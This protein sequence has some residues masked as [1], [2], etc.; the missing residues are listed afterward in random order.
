MLDRFQTLVTKLQSTNGRIEKEAFLREVADDA[1]V[2]EILKFLFDPYVVS[3]ISDKKLNKQK[4]AKCGDLPLL[5][6]TNDGGQMANRCHLSSDICH[7]LAYFRKNNTGRDEDVRYLVNAAEKSGHAE[8]VY[9]IIKRDLKLGIQATTLNKVFGEDFVAKFDV[10]LAESYADNPTFL[11][12]KEFII[13]EKLDGVRCLLMNTAGG[14]IDG[15]W[16]FYSRQ[17]QAILDLVELIEQ[18]KHLPCEF[19]YDGELLLSTKQPMPSKDLYR[20]TV[21]VTSSDTTK[22]NIVFNMFDMVDK[23]AFLRGEDPTPAIERKTR[24]QQLLD[25]HEKDCPNIK[26]VIMQYVGCDTSEI[27]KYLKQFTDA[28]GEGIM[29]SIS[30]GA[31]QCK[32]TKNLLKV[33]QFNTADVEVLQLE[34]GSGANRGKLGAVIVKFLG[35]DGK[36]YKCKVG[37]G[38]KLEEREFFW[39]NPG[40]IKGKIIEIGYF[41]LSKNQNNDDYSLRFPTFK[42]VRLDKDEISMYT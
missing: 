6:M 42:H 41:E 26:P 28:D 23:A 7:L 37:S 38:F 11:N 31:Y 17:G 27:N 4:K 10:M 29:V 25:K 36:H 39:K 35:P 21:K 12:D 22:R 32:R 2:L 9:S 24:L 20:E 1:E 5:K 40:Q 3:G 19:V 33:K 14:H 34:E 8:L 15:Q 18:V 13:T 30:D 16:I